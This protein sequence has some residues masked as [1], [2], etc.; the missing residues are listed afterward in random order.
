MAHDDDVIDLTQYLAGP[1][2]GE[3][4]AFSVF[5]GGGPSSRFALPVWRSVYLLQGN[6]GGVLT[7]SDPD[8][9]VAPVFLLDLA[10]DPARVDLPMEGAQLLEPHRRGDRLVVNAEGGW[11]AV[12]LGDE[13]GLVYFTVVTG[14]EDTSIVSE[15]EV[16][17]DF[18]FLAGECS[19]LIFHWG[20]GEPHRGDTE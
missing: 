16:R 1:A 3:A 11:A 9:E 4:S 5:G 13:D 7:V 15:M 10:E 8:G 14:M 6:R 12:K 19:G 2:P 18:L 17:Q 20:L